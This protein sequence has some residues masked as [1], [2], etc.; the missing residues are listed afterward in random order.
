MLLKL[1]NVKPMPLVRPLYIC[2]MADGTGG[3]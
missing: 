3:Q 2:G 1:A